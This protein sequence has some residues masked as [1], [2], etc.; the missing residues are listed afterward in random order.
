L[1]GLMTLNVVGRA[2]EFSIRKVLGAGLKN[3]AANILKQYVILFAVA[4]IIGAPISYVLI[5]LVI[6][7]AYVYHM[8]IT[9]SGVAI[10]VAILILVLLATVAIQIRKVLISNPVNGLK[11]E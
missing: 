5:K 2:R 7:F 3:I 10:A 11:A 1:Y 8:P 6:E 4:L 9:Y